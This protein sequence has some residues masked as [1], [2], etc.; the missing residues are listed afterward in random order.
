MHM[1]ELPSRCTLGSPWHTEV[2][3]FSSWMAHCFSPL[4]EVHTHRNQGTSASH[5]RAIESPSR[6]I[7]VFNGALLT[8]SIA[9]VGHNITES[10]EA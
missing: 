3:L 8:M 10:T 7:V 4:G 5:E 1:A 6:I 2:V 9:S